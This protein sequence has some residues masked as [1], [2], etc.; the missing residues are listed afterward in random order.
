MFYVW[1][2]VDDKVMKV[3]MVQTLVSEVDEYAN[4]RIGRE[5]KR[6]F[7]A[8]EVTTIYGAIQMCILLLLLL[9]SEK[10][11]VPVFRYISRRVY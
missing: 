5:M 9:L 8:S 7:S 3:E 6:N 10:Y 1:F 11:C 4:S 2:G